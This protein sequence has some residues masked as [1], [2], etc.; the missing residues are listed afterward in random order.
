MFCLKIVLAIKI[1]FNGPR[2]HPAFRTLH[3][4]PRC[5]NNTEDSNNRDDFWASTGDYIT[6]RGGYC[7]VHPLSKNSF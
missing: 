7:A 3:T 5:T 1:C 4:T 6:S 2:G